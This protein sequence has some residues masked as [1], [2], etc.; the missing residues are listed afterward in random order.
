MVLGDSEDE[1][2]YTDDERIVKIESSSRSRSEELDESL[3]EFYQGSK[4][5]VFQHQ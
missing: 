3:Q 1:A 5:Q 4:Y 2:V